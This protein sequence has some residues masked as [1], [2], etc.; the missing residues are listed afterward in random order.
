MKKLY[1]HGMDIFYILM[2]AGKGEKPHIAHNGSDGKNYTLTWVSLLL[3][4]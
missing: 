2:H 1:I 3:P 4:H